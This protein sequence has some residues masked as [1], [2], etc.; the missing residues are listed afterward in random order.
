MTGR[1]PGL[2]LHSAT[3][4]V[5]D[6]KLYFAF[7]CTCLEVKAVEGLGTTIDVILINGLI[8]IKI[9]LSFVARN[10]IVT[11]VEHDSSCHAGIEV[12]NDYENTSKSRHNG[13]QNFCTKSSTAVAGQMFLSTDKKKA[14]SGGTGNSS[15]RA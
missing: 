6:R 9:I 5:D 2:L 7:E 3:N 1:C 10:L 15:G 8:P 11:K 13:N 4:E 12:K 14:I